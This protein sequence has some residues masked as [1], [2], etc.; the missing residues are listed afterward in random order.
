MD[1]GIEDVCDTGLGLGLSYKESVS[2]SIDQQWRRG[3]PVEP[4]LTL[5][6]SGDPFG[7]E[8]KAKQP[9][10]SRW[11][12]CFSVK[13]KKDMREDEAET[14]EKVLTGRA[15]DEEEDGGARKKLRLTK[16]QSSLLEKSFKEHTTLTPKQK[17]ALAKH[18]D[19]RPR[20]VEVWFQN[21][22]ARTKLKQTEVDCVF[23]KK[24]FE[25]LTDENRRLQKE[26]QELK[27]L[28]YFQPSTHMKIATTTLRMCP[29][30]DKTT[31]RDEDGA[32]NIAPSPKPLF[33]NYF[34]H[35]ATC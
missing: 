7:S 12:Y 15:S 35:S 2:I 9:Q 13:R 31:G 33:F 32:G 16:E 21:R 29:K 27:R 10:F 3:T 4:S 19:L 11:K 23:L 28:K 1:K 24:C 14:H 22:R 8:S 6:L 34:T 5:G 20:Q 17:Q 26:L 25:T 30:C 18:L